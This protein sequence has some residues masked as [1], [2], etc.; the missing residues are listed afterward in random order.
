MIQDV[1]TYTQTHAWSVTV[2]RQT[3]RG[4][5]GG[6]QLIQCLNEQN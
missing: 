1:V 5:A 3:D 4:T 6:Q 2:H